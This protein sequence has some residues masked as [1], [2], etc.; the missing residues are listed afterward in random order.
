MIDWK[1]VGYV[2]TPTSKTQ[3]DTKYLIVIKVGD[4]QWKH[5]VSWN[6]V[7]IMNVTPKDV[8]DYL[9]NAEFSTVSHENHYMF[10]VYE[11]H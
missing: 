2:F 5:T 3:P 9:S 11:Y 4:Y 8:I 10:H 1:K 7:E 6:Q